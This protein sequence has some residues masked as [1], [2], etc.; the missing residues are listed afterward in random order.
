MFLAL[1]TLKLPLRLTRVK[2]Y[3]LEPDRTVQWTSEFELVGDRTLTP[4][5][6]R[7][8][9]ENPLVNAIA[10]PLALI[11]ATIAN[12]IVPI[13]MYPM[14]LWIH[15]LGHAT[16]AWLAGY[17]AMPL[18]FGWT[19]VSAEPSGFVYL[20]ILF[21]LGLLFWAGWRERKRG[22]MVLAGGLAVVQFYM[23]WLLPDRAFDMLVT[24]GGIGGEFCLSTL[25]MACFYIRMPD[26]LR[27]DF[28]R[29]VVLFAAAST[30]CHAF[31][32]WHLIDLGVQDIPWG[33]IFGQGD[34]G[35]D[36]NRLNFEHGWSRERIIA[37]Y[38]RLGEVCLIAIVGIYGFF[39]VKLNRQVWF[40]LRQ[41]AIA[42]QLEHNRDRP[43]P[44][45][46]SPR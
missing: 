32:Q 1:K 28:W 25:L 31:W 6:N 10:L 43:R 7:F 12:T 17:R 22:A 40:G 16:V 24:F 29:F 19:S 34:A 14:Q 23:T 45:A 18:P 3:G 15:E 39:A 33:S 2:L 27:W 35:G 11:L 41:R 36:M 46:R 21:L 42:W 38:S 9:F 8:S 26:R 37:T 44:S 13:L 30:F 5:F 4:D 20:G